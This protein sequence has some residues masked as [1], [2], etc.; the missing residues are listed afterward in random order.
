MSSHVPLPKERHSKS[1]LFATVSSLSSRKKEHAKYIE[2]HPFN[3]R[4]SVIV[5]KD[6]ERD[7]RQLLEAHIHEYYRVSL[8]LTDLIDPSFIQGYV[9]N[10]GLV[11]L[12]LGMRIDVDDVFAIDGQSRLV[13]SL[14]KD[15][16][17]ALGLAGQQAQ[18]PL[19]RGTRFIVTVDLLAIDPEKNKFRRIHSRLDAVFGGKEFEFA[20]GLYDRDTGK[21]LTL[22]IPGAS[23]CKPQIK[24]STVLG[25]DVPD[26][27]DL[28]AQETV[29]RESLDDWCEQA[30]DVFEWI[31]LTVAGA[32]PAICGGRSA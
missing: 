12:S 24:V 3:H 1:K 15:T 31:G 18:F 22:D 7:T 9:A 6:K 10:K 11:A 5:S 19:E 8:K 32:S 26:L 23:A 20:V 14:C 17:Q 21:A 16:Y 2:T 13:M 30:Q 29:A 4:L 25:V 27:T 28:L